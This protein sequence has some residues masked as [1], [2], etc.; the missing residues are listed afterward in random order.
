MSR[1][2]KRKVRNFLLDTRFQLK[3][4]LFVVGV[5]VAIF[6]GLGSLYWTELR[7]STKLMEINQEVSKVLDAKGLAEEID[8]HSLKEFELEMLPEVRMRDV[9]AVCM[10]L[11]AV[12]GLVL[13]LAAAGIYMTHKVAGPL[14]ALGSFMQ[15]A[16][17]GNW[18]M[19]RPFR[20]GDE[21]IWLS[22]QF[23][24][25]AQSIKERHRFEHDALEEISA[26][27]A[28]GDFAGAQSRVTELI[29]DKRRFIA[30]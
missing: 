11:A 2:Y 27:L 18:K 26:R 25:L 22:D 9:R 1:P 10:L 4:T 8:P 14:Y 20:K 30:S 15:A 24:Q 3:Y 17:Q 13:L 21:F 6:S 5:S 12:S 19:I 16:C 28:K 23:Q 7:A 29:E